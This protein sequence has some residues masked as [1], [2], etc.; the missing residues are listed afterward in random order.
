MLFPLYIHI[1]LIEV[2]C[3]NNLG[4]IT[5]FIP[6]VCCRNWKP[7]TQFKR[8]FNV[9][10]KKLKISNSWSHVPLPQ[11]FQF[12]LVL[13]CLTPHS[14]IFQLYRGI[15]FYWWRK[16]EYPENSTELSQ[17]T[18]KLYHIMLYWVHPTMSMLQTHNFSDDRY[19]LHK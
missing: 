17:V 7:L 14:M 15:H 6:K 8:F 11:V 12:R 4:T 1:W 3:R 16:L 18:D 9:I 13:W 19:W 5:C 10:P 2:H